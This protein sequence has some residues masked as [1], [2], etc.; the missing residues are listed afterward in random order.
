MGL[1]GFSP[2]RSFADSLVNSLWCPCDV[3]AQ[4]MTLLLFKRGGRGGKGGGEEEEEEKGLERKG[5]QILLVFFFSLIHC[6]FCPFCPLFALL[7]QSSTL[8]HVPW[9]H[10]LPLSLLHPHFSPTCTFLH[11]NPYL[12]FFPPF[13]LSLS[14]QLLSSNRKQETHL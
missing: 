8:F 4:S 9:P 6:H 7:G 13:S 10:S 1:A 5:I 12:S 3:W 11:L 14:L 2:L